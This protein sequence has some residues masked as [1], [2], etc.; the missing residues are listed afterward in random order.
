[1]FRS[2][3]RQSERVEK[4]VYPVSPAH[5]SGLL[6]FRASQ[7]MCVLSLG[8]SCAQVG[9]RISPSRASS[10][11]E[12]DSCFSWLPDPSPSASGP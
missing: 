12:V 10:R 6:V 3:T 8:H 11:T 7:L 1:M 2:A 5:V 9:S 4:A